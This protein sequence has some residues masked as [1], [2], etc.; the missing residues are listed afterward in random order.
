MATWQGLF[1]ELKGED[2]I[3][4]NLERSFN[5]A[6]GITIWSTKGV[7][8]TKLNREDLRTTPR[9]HRFAVVP[10]ENSSRPCNPWHV[11]KFYVH[12]YQTKLKLG[13]NFFKTLNSK[14]IARNLK[15]MYGIRYLPRP[16]D[17]S[18]ESTFHGNY[19]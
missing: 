11:G 9:P 4:E 17:L 16:N 1:F 18:P 8:I 12:V 5:T 10:G 19:D 15:E 6:R 2:I 3:F 13:D 7:Q 14:A